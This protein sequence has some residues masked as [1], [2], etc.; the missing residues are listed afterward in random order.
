MHNRP[1]LVLAALLLAS[2]SGVSSTPT[3]APGSEGRTAWEQ[4]QR[5][6]WGTVTGQN[7]F[8]ILGSRSREAKARQEEAGGVGVNSY[9]WR[10]SLDTIDFMPVSAADPFGGLIT[11]DWYQPT[12][13]PTERFKLQ[14]LIRDRSLRAD[15]VKVSVW[16]QTK[17]ADG[18]WLDAPVDPKTASELEDKILTRARELRI[19][20]SENS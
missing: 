6:R 5:D 19:A 10:A 4:A 18:N 8:S 15:G 1:I 16:R 20:G 3:P 17:D 2:C 12:E 7:G 11:T 9:L 13:T 14:V